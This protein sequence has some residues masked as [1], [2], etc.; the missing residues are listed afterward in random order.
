MWRQI[1]RRFTSYVKFKRVKT[2]ASIL[3]RINDSKAEITAIPRKTDESNT[4]EIGLVTIKYGSSIY[5]LIV[6]NM[7]ATKYNILNS[8]EF[9]ADM[10]TESLLEEYL[11]E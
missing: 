8:E 6:K 10:K 9:T 2:R 3:Q 4:E 7:I 11:F 5:N 1:I